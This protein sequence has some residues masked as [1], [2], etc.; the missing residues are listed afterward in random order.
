[1][2]GASGRRSIQGDATSWPEKLDVN[3]IAEFRKKAGMDLED[4]ADIVGIDVVELAMAERGI[5]L[6]HLDVIAA[7]ATALDAEPADLYPTVASHIRGAEDLDEEQL[8]MRLLEPECSAALMAAGVD[9]D[10]ACWYVIVKLK[11]G[12][13]RRYR[14]SSGEKDR[15]R[16]ALRGPAPIDSYLL[17]H[18][19]CRNVAIRR[20]AIA[21]LR[22][23][24]SASYA[25]FSSHESAFDVLIIS[26]RS[27]RP[28]TIKAL[29]DGGPDGKGP[30]PFTDFMEAAREGRETGA[31]LM[32]EDDGDE[33]FVGIDQLEL[34]EVPVGVMMPDIYSDASALPP[35]DLSDG[36]ESMEPMGEA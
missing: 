10:I 20:N 5:G 4:V 8:R 17:F 19:D 23:T 18:A 2:T 1:M 11:S 22:F 36:L 31:F 12:N 3:R 15:I 26:P 34:I 9:P 14:V 6:A 24:N 7:V 33:H 25:P 30:T 35:P 32:L 21:E 29:P 16:A 13:E 27:P 28:E